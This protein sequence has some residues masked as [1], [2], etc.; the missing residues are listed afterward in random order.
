MIARRPCSPDLI[1]SFDGFPCSC[2]VSESGSLIRNDE[3][4]LPVSRGALP[5]KKPADDQDSP[6]FG[7]R[8]TFR[9]A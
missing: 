2:A 4:D 6:S 9:T 7:Q 5:R 3:V 8:S 1:G